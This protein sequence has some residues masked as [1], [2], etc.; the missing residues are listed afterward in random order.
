LTLLPVCI[1]ILPAAGTAAAAHFAHIDAV[2]YVTG[3]LGAFLAFQANRVKFVFDE[4]SLEVRVLL[5]LI[6]W[7][8]D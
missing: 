1:I 4:D 8:A 7:L 3:V 6:R 5:F 2:S